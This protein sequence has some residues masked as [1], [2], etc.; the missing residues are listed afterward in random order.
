[1]V[2]PRNRLSSLVYFL[3][4]L[5]YTFECQINVSILLCHFLPIIQDLCLYLVCQKCPLFCL[6]PHRSNFCFIIEVYRI[7]KSMKNLEDIQITDRYLLSKLFWVQ[8]AMN[9]LLALYVYNDPPKPHLV[10]DYDGS[11]DY[12]HTCTSESV[13]LLCIGC[14]KFFLLCCVFSLFYSVIPLCF[15]SGIISGVLIFGTYISVKTRNVPDRWNES[16]AVAYVFFK[17]CKKFFAS[18]SKIRFFFFD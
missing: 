2:P 4:E 12:Y 10:Q 13:Y 18:F 6:F 7:F 3:N 5:V 15:L 11:N 8:L 17:I 16:H 1:M 14:M 9:L